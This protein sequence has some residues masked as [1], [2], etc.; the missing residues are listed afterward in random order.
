M[1]F[2][3]ILF[4]G[5]TLTFYQNGQRV[6]NPLTHNHQLSDNLLHINVGYYRKILAT[7][8]ISGFEI[9]SKLL[10]DLDIE[11]LYRRDYWC[12]KAVVQ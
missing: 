4:S 9:R 12:Q 7:A 8:Y 1:T 10:S 5:G 2:L 11:I 3:V 6:G